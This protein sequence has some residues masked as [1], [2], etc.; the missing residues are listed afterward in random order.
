[1]D[2]KYGTAMAEVKYTS[3]FAC[4]EDTSHLGISSLCLGKFKGVLAAWWNICYVAV[5]FFSL[6]SK[7]ICTILET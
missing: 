2:I 6:A 5:L 1:M 3:P 7:Y 4:I